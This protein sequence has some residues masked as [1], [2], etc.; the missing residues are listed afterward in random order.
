M[1]LGAGK[2]VDLLCER[3]EEAWVLE[4]KPTLTWEAFGQAL[5]YRWLFSQEHPDVRVY[6]GVVCSEGNSVIEA[7]CAAPEFAVTVFLQTDDGFDQR[8]FLCETPSRGHH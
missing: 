6:C 7:V 2:Q 3:Q 1:G 8:G 4:V 5:G